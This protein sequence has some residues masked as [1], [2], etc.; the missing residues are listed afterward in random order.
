MQLTKYYIIDK[1]IYY[2]NDKGQLVYLEYTL[3]GGIN[4]SC[5]NVEAVTHYPMIEATSPE[6]AYDIYK[7]LY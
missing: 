6:E 4:R 3:G 2:V 5:H 1:N 7:I